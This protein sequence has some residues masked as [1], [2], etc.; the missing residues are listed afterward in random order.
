MILTE[1]YS[2]LITDSKLWQ[3]FIILLFGFYSRLLFALPLTTQSSGKTSN[4]SSAKD[5]KAKGNTKYI[6]DFEK[7]KFCLAY[8]LG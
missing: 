2:P 1:F 3:M 8:R 5:T 7:L 4:P 6:I